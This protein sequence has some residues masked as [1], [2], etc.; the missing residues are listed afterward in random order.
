MAQRRGPSTALSAAGGFARG[1]A[2]TFVG[3][4]EAKRAEEERIREETRRRENELELQNELEGLKFRRQFG[5]P[6]GA[7]TPQFPGA[8]GPTVGIEDV[9]EHGVGEAQ[10]GLAFERERQKTAGEQEVATALALQK[11]KADTPEGRAAAAREQLGLDIR[12]AELA[13]GVYQVAIKTTEQRMADPN[14]DPSLYAV[15]LGE[16]LTRAAGISGVDVPADL[17]PPPPAEITQQAYVDLMNQFD[18]A[19]DAKRAIQDLEDK[20]GPRPDNATKKQFEQKFGVKFDTFARVAEA[21]GGLAGDVRESVAA[22]LAAGAGEGR[23]PTVQPVGL[24]GRLAGEPIRGAAAAA[25]EATRPPGLAAVLP[26]T[27]GAQGLAGPGPAAPAPAVAG[28]SLGP[29]GAEATPARSVPPPTPAVP[30]VLAPAGAVE[31]GPTLPTLPPG[32]SPAIAMAL[33]IITPEQFLQM[34]AMGIPPNSP[35][36]TGQFAAPGGPPPSTPQFPTT[37]QPPAINPSMAPPGPGTI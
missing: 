18:D 20:G 36:P 12:K 2:K 14:I 19:G 35:T 25:P 6:R 30:G 33:G 28:L 27:A 32:V 10:L 13:L 7:V 37:G 34:I 23:Q 22:F 5:F 1:F 8:A 9:L 21:V 4:L 29:R 17:L 15:V 26:F 24:A 31:I 16:E 3:R 11:A